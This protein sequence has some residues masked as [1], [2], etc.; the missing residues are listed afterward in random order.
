MCEKTTKVTQWLNKIFGD[1]PVPY[2]E[3]N[4]RTIDVLYQL[5]Q[6]SEAR[7]KD[8]TLVLE[9]LKQQAAEYSAD[10]SYVQDLL[11]QAVG[12]SSSS[13]SKRA[14]S[15]LSVLEGSAVAL[16]T[17][18]T[19][20][21]SFVAAMNDLTAELMTVEK[22]NRQ[23][24]QDLTILRRKLTAAI[25]QRK[26]LQEDLTKTEESE[27]VENARAENRLQNLDF[28]RA[29]SED[30]SFRIKTA[31]DQLSA[32]GMEPSLTH[33]AIVELSEK[34]AKL[35]QETVPLK[36]K[37]ESYLDLT[38]NPSLAQVKIEEAKRELAAI[39][40]EL[41]MKVDIVNIA[42]PEQRGRH[43]K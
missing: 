10:G 29:K 32:T 6:S 23:M 22:K 8:E 20:L 40:A 19:S 33:Q 26:A 28:L 41:T 13:L 16:N 37:L 14:F 18:D 1:Q 31:E 34:L 17:K 12:L 27:E 7:C 43:L 21:A 15:N 39:D 36:K 4:S 9:D 11:L 5:A 35:K 25:V 42:L 3:V 2:Y 30:L 38:P 24:D